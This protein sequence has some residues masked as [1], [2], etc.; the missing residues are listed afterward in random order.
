MELAD[1]LRV[2]RNH[3][4]GIALITVLV[5]AGALVWSLLQPKVYAAE[6]TGVVAI[7]GTNNTALDSVGDTLA[8]SRAAS[9]VDV[10]T[11]RPVADEVI[12]MLHLDDSPADLVNRISVRQPT[13]T[14]LLEITADGSSPLQAEQLADAWVKA[15]SQTVAKL[16]NPTGS[17]TAQVPE[18]KVFASAA[19]P[20]APVSPNPKRDG[21]IGLIIGLMLGMAYAVIRSHF[22]RRLRSSAEIEQRFKVSVVGSIPATK[23]LVTG[24]D[25]A[26]AFHD[27]GSVEGA[28]YAAHVS[29]EAFRKLRTNLS[30]MDIDNPPRIIVVTSSLPGDGKSTVAASLAA[31]VAASGQPVLLVDA[32]LRRPVVARLMG[33]VE[34]AG[35]TDVLVGR[36]E[37]DDV[38]QE[39]A[40]VPGLKVLAA[41]SIPPNPSELLAS[42]TLRDLLH[43][44]SKTAMIILDAPPLL[45]VT[46]AAILAT[47]CDG[48]IVVASYGKTLD[49]ELEEALT[50]I[51]SVN[52]RVLGVVFN[53]TPERKGWNS[54]Y[55]GRYNNQGPTPTPEPRVTGGKHTAAGSSRSTATADA[56]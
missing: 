7:S 19:L 8:K 44:W 20:T 47:A 14:I 34:G 29:N 51:R 43:E 52:S 37:L 2:M 55:G 18:V 5:T 3:P 25:G 40:D 12:R 33:L 10:A 4:L 50:N 32:D 31:A 9:Y 23:S 16:E 38:T 56:G 17:S 26:L 36:V 39:R 11:S 13:D 46:D 21:L 35:L 28:A 48:A 27:G 54:Y 30:Y 53:R 49:N 22:D 45:P 6:A 41:G 1:Y 42:N 15:L 24:P